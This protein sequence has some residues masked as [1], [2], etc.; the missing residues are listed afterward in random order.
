MLDITFGG[1]LLAGLLAFF[2][3]C[4]LPMVPFYLSYMAGLSMAELRGEGAI[5]PGAQ[6][7]LFLSALMFALGVTTIFM[8]M[9][10]GATA[11]GQ[12]FRDWFGVLRY[13]AAAVIFAFGLH[14]LGV[15]RIG[16]LYREAR[17]QSSMNPSTVLGAYAM[18]LAF[19]FGWSACVGP[20]LATI[21]MMAS[22][23]GDVL[24][25]GLL[26]AVFGFGMTA[27]FV[28]AALFARPFLGW[29]QRHRKYQAHVEKVL[30]VMLIVFA[31]LIAT[32]SVNAIANWMIETF[33]VF[34]TIG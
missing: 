21:L 2:T 17:M 16:I 24:Q 12:A 13:A 5:A 20:I 27:P 25:G 3:P 10:M 9:G 11:L 31:L 4:I 22:G 30:G 1:A 33:P 6:R 18:G 19:G 34:A 8:L 23:M 26:L 7:R 15:I 14:F 32:G 29:M 28:V